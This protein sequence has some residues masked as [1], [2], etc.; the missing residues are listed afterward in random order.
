MEPYMKNTLAL[1]ILTLAAFF[2]LEIAFS[3]PE[4][5]ESEP[6]NPRFEAV[7]SEQQKSAIFAGGCFWCVE[8]DF[9][10]LDGVIEAISGYSGG[11]AATANYKQVSHTETGHFEVVKVVYDASQISYA[12]LVEF[13]WRQ[14]D[15]TDPDGQFCDKGSSYKSAIFYA[16]DEEKLVVEQSLN[17]LNKSKPFSQPIVTTIAA[18]KPFYPAEQYHQNYYSKNPIRYNYYR[19]GCRRDKRLEQLWGEK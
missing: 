1:V 10:K 9:E 6:N 8:S 2:S 18:A 3:K 11:E 4:G 15:P 13:F 17:E 5:S 19:K 14:I 16:N 12:Q 7:G